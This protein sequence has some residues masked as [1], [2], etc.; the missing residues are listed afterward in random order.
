MTKVVEWVYNHCYWDIKRVGIHQLDI[1]A[2]LRMGRPDSK[3]S[4]GH[5]I[6]RENEDLKINGSNGV[7]KVNI[8]KAMEAMTH[9]LG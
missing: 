1:W 6:K 3:Y 7:P 5:Y 8:E 2:F 9:L 4:N